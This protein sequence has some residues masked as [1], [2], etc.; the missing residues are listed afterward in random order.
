[1]LMHQ[2]MQSRNSVSDRFYRALYAVLLEPALPRS[3]SAAM[4]LALLFR[5]LRADVNP[6]R[7][8]ALVKR[9]LQ[10]R[11]HAHVPACGMSCRARALWA[12][13]SGV[14][15]PHTTWRGA[16]GCGPPRAAPFYK[17]FPTR[18]SP[19]HTRSADARPPA[20]KWHPR[21]R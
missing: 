2:L 13:A 15:T 3:A 19:P 12:A 9:L 11:A 5:A 6:K 8:A 10:V 7:V 21:R 17:R 18:R 20:A 16:A 14:T 1:M 4:F